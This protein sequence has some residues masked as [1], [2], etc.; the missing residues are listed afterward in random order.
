MRLPADKVK[1]A[2]LH[3][4]Q[5]VREAAVY[6]Y[7]AKSFSTDPAI[8]PLA[9]QAIDR[10]GFENAFRV[11]SF[12]EDLVQTN[13]SIADEDFDFGCRVVEALGHHRDH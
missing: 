5:D 13:G 2:I 7:F 8:M 3:A 4:N 12:L 1:E 11:Y 6:Y 9:I 10:F